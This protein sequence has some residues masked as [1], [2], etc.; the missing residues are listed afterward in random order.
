ML[1]AF[2]LKNYKNFKDEVAFSM[3]KSEKQRDLT[4]SILKRKIKRRTYQALCSSVIYGPNASGK[5]N[6][7]GAMEAFKAII[8]RGHIR[9]EDNFRNRNFAMHRLELIPNSQNKTCGPVEFSIEFI[10]ADKLFSYELRADI[11][12]FM[13][14]N[15]KRSIIF[16]R[17]T[18]N[19]ELI[20]V[21]NKRALEFG[22]FS[23]I[24]QQMNNDHQRAREAA[25]DIAA[26]GLNDDE[27]FLSNG[28]KSIFSIQV[29]DE[30][31]EWFEF[32]LD[33][34]YS[35]ESVT[36]VRADETLSEGPISSP[37]VNAIA[38]LFGTNSEKLAYVQGDSGT[39]LFSFFDKDKTTFAVLSEIYESYG[40]TRIAQQAPRVAHALLHGRVL[41]M[42]EFDASLHPMVVMSIIKLFHNETINKNHAQL[43]FNTHNPIF[44]SGDLFRRDEIKFV[45]QDSETESSVV[46]SLADFGTQ[47]NGGRKHADYMKH[48]FKNR[49]GALKHV[50]LE[51]IFRKV[52]DGEIEV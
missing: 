22:C 26:N 36:Y 52:I 23:E 14:R 17:L 15:A 12:C 1:L 28:F 39:E 4:Y 8:L 44:L 10:H 50:D 32:N 46:Y 5:T 35:S 20:F 24:K 31:R 33:I 27:L 45:E 6:L 29:F 13:E 3:K 9:N 16:E 49:Y 19:E 51:P 41:I 21:R 2:K 11:G 34:V 43:I 37:L 40:T 42:D 38:Q 48:Y 25:Q 47:Q 7:I 30:M 18:V